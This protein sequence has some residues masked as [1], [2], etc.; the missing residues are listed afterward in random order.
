MKT[1]QLSF[2]LPSTDDFSPLIEKIKEGKNILNQMI[3]SASSSF[4]SASSDAA[5]TSRLQ[6]RKFKRFMK[7]SKYLPFV[8]VGILFLLILGYGL[9]KVMTKPA[10]TNENTVTSNGRVEL[11]K[12]LATQKL[13]KEVDFP[14][15][16]ATGKQ[17]S[18]IKLVVLNLEMRD[19]IIIQGKI[20]NTTVGKN[21]LIANIELTNNFTKPV[22]IN[23]RNYFRLM[24]NKDGKL[25]DPKIHNDPVD[26]QPV[27]TTNTRVGFT[28]DDTDHDFVL[29]IGDVTD[30]TSK[31][32]E[33][34][35]TNLR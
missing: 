5:N 1:I 13:N 34:N 33:V 15:K 10:A 28:V 32:Q 9:K 6:M 11:R 14:L 4:S 26:V 16:D 12:P 30:P 23:S 7:D 31:I 8:V 3:N 25:Y 2:P 24:K 29:R 22:Q 21:V 35:I 19:Q 27:S 17:I 20:A 18:T